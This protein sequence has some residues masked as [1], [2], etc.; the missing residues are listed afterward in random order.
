[1]TYRD[2]QLNVLI[3]RENRLRKKLGIADMSIIPDMSTYPEDV[4]AQFAE[5]ERELAVLAGE[6]PG[7]VV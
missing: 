1:M 4:R 7:V 3:D 6:K 5:I 2:I